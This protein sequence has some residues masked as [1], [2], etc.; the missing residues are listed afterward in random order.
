MKIAAVTPKI[1]L[2]DCEYN[3]DSMAEYAEKAAAE[4]CRLVV[5]PELVLTGSTCGDVLGNADFEK[6]TAT[7]LEKIRGETAEL[8]DLTI[9]FGAPF[10][11][12]WADTEDKARNEDTLESLKDVRNENVVIKGDNLCSEAGVVV[13]SDAPCKGKSYRS[14]IVI[15]KNSDLRY[16][17]EGDL[18]EI[19]GKKMYFITGPANLKNKA[20]PVEVDG[21]SNPAGVEDKKAD[22]ILWMCNLEYHAGSQCEYFQKLKD[23]SKETSA[24]VICVSSGEGESTDECIY[25]SLKACVCGGEVT[26]YSVKTGLCVFDTDDRESVNHP[27]YEKDNH[28]FLPTDENA[29]DYFCVDI[30][31]IQAKALAGRLDFL[32][33]KKCIIGLSGGL[34]STLALVAAVNAFD[35]S[36]LDRKGII[37]VT[38]PGFGTGNVTKNNAHRLAEA[39]GVTLREIDIKEQT[40]LHLRSIGQ[41]ENDGAFVSDVT[42]ENAQARMRTMILMDIANM[43]NS[44]VIGTG[45]MSELALGW[46]TYN[47]DHMSMYSVNSGVPK[48]AIAPVLRTYAKRIAHPA[49]REL[50]SG[51]FESI[52]ETPVSPELMPTDERGEVVQRTEDSLGPYELHDY[53]LYMFL[54]RDLTTEEIYK[55]CAEKF[56]GTY[57]K[58]FILKTLK[59]FKKRFFTQQFKRSCMPVGAKVMEYSLSPRSGFMMASD[60]YG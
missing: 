55:R 31:N 7:A 1:H 56:E 18:V 41:P 54:K 34:D 20:E 21:I 30:L 2:G 35:R 58:E 52:I 17:N 53:F 45:D 23:L 38:M 9:V 33:I 16:V 60:L 32:N 29:R 4:G 48:T 19:D 11:G 28:G 13:K 49:E 6:A 22:I 43:E 37:C 5:F 15:I 10:Y 27:A 24:D 47:G 57:D 51:I 39:F 8:K 25:S 42:F 59:I 44:I 14:G 40:A 12:E 26:D 50:L 46:C 36:G 3:V